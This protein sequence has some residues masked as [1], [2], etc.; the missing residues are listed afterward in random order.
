ML[1]FSKDNTTVDPDF[2]HAAKVIEYSLDDEDKKDILLVAF[3]YADSDEAM[4]K[5]DWKVAKFFFPKYAA[6]PIA[7]AILECGGDGEVQWASPCQR[8]TDVPPEQSDPSSFD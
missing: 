3:P 5:K 7:A 4:E 1:N 8:D 2:L 6:P